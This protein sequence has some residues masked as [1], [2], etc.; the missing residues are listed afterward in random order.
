MGRHDVPAGAQRAQGHL[1]GG[2]RVPSHRG[3]VPA[4]RKKRRHKGLALLLAAVFCVGIAVPWAVQPENLRPQ[5]DQL[6]AFLYRMS[7]GDSS[8][9][10]EALLLTDLSNSTVFLSKNEDNPV[11]PASLAKLFVVEY[12]AGLLGQDQVV[13]VTPEALSLVKPGSSMA[14]L[15]AKEY[16]VKDLF[17]AMLLPSGN[18]AAYAVADAA[19]SQLSPESAPGQERVDAFME[20]LR[21]HLQQQGYEGTALYDPSGYDF[22]ARTTARD[23]TRVTLR[24]LEFPWFREMVSQEA[25]TAAL[26][27]GTSQTW[28]TTNAFLQPDSG[29]Y[30]EGVQGVKTGSLEQTYNLMVLYEQHG[31]EFLVCSLGSSSDT[32]RYDDVS[33]ILQTVD[34]SGYLVW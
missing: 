4:R 6:Q 15:E 19:G 10:G 24:L 33:H 25:Y 18:D 26:P 1:R 2:V 14:W 20:G 16:F 13:S 3:T 23:L 11:L 17:A 29:Y 7:Y 30:E 27:D 34:E 5:K 12:A 8:Y 28:E 21:G 22:Q 31:K 32:A 9:N